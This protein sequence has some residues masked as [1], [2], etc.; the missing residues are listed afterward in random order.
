LSQKSKKKV[1]KGNTRADR[2]GGLKKRHEPARMNPTVFNTRVW[3]EIGDGDGEKSGDWGTMRDKTKD[4]IKKAHRTITK[5]R[6]Y[7]H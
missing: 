2:E 6:I 3:G 1:G 5:I 7:E 4:V